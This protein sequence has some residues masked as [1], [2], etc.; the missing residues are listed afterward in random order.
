MVCHTPCAVSV[1]VTRPSYHPVL[2]S[3]KHRQLDGMV[4]L[5]KLGLAVRWGMDVPH[6]LVYLN[7]TYRGLRVILINVVL[8]SKCA[9]IEDSH[10]LTR[11]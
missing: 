9:K 8:N 11:R 3:P 4:Q 10:S 2:P 7:S 1:R 6:S 5:C